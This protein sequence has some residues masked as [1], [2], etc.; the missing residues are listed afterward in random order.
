MNTIKK[1]LALIGL[2]LLTSI[3]FAQQK[4]VMVMEIK[5]E[6]DPRM[7]RYVELALKMQ[8]KQ[9]QI[10]LSLKWIPMAVY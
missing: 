3:S 10:S 4:K 6:I 8:K 7:T 5:N 2:L 1:M 9:K